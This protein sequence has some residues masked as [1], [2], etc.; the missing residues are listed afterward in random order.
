[1]QFLP[2]GPDIPES[3]Y[4]AHQD[5]KVVFFCGAGISYPAGL[6]GFKGLV[7]QLYEKLGETKNPPEMVA[8]NDTRYDLVID[9]LERRLENRDLVRKKISEILT[10]NNTKPKQY[11]T[12]NALLIL[13]SKSVTTKNSARRLVTTNFDRLFFSADPNHKHFGAPLLPIPKK[14]RWDGVV[15]LHGLLPESPD[16][17]LLSNLVVSSGDFGLAY[18]TERW[19]SRFVTD[20]FRE[21]TVCFVG[22][23]LGDPVLRY[24]VDA[25][26]ADHLRGEEPKEV[27]AFAS[28]PSG[29]G[30]D[31]RDEWEAKGITPILYEEANDHFYLHKSLETWA[32]DYR[33]GVTGKQM[34]VTEHSNSTPDRFQEGG[35]LD[36]MVWALSDPSGHP[37]KLFAEMDPIPPIDWLNVLDEKGL[38]EKDDPEGHI[39]R[40][41][42]VAQG[43]FVPNQFLD[44]VTLQLGRWLVKYLEKTEVMEW[45]VHKRGPLHADFKRL[46]L[47]RLSKNDLPQPVATIWQ[48][49]CA[50]R[51][52]IQARTWGDFGQV[53]KSTGWNSTQRKELLRSLEPIV[54]FE[55]SHSNPF[56][57]D[58]QE[59]SRK[60]ERVHDYLGWDIGLKASDDLRYYVVDDLKKRNDWGSI[61][62]DLLPGLTERLKDA[63][64][65][66]AEL[67]GADKYNDL[68]YYR[69]PSISNH[70]QNKDYYHWTLLIELCRDGWLAAKSQDPGLAR[71]E[72]ERWKLISY[73][74]FRRLVFFAATQSPIVTPE[75]ALELLLAEEARWL[76]STNTQREAFQL[77]RFLAPKLAVHPLERLCSAILAGP[78]PG[79]HKVDSDENEILWMTK[80][81]WLRLK[82]CQ[83]QDGN[84]LPHAAAQ[85][86]KETQDQHPEWK[87]QPEERDD[88]PSWMGEVGVFKDTPPWITRGSVP[89]ALEELVS[90]LAERKESTWEEDDWK[91]L[92]EKEPELAYNALKALADEKKWPIGVWKSALHGFSSDINKQESHCSRWLGSL[93]AQAPEEFNR[94]S[95]HA[96][97]WWIAYQPTVIIQE[98]EPIWFGLIDH[99]LG[100]LR[101][102]EYEGG[103]D[104]NTAAINHPVG[105]V[106]EAMIKYWYLSEPKGGDGLKDPFLSRFTR[107]V[108]DSAQIYLHGRVI[109]AHHLYSLFSVDEE[110]SK[111]YLLPK[112]NW[113]DKNP[114][115]LP[116]W[117]GYLS[118]AKISYPLLDAM[119]SSF[120]Q[121]ASHT[122]ELALSGDNYAALLII[123]ALDKTHPLSKVEIQNALNSLSLEGLAKAS[124][125]LHQML[126]GAG[127]K[128]SEYW[129][130][131]I[132]PLLEGAWPKSANMRSPEESE[133]MVWVCTLAGDSFPDAVETM[134]NLGFIKQPSKHITFLFNLLEKAELASQFPRDTIKLL[135]VMIPEKEISRYQLSEIRKFLNQMVEKDASLRDDQIYITIDLRL[136]KNRL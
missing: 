41:A 89:R 2:K 116:L 40:I 66:M 125:R 51:H 69:R 7:D 134:I 127:D 30:K 60:K 28:H 121:T 49:M 59:G 112:F 115:T 70:S 128:A 1:M 119:K 82:M 78:P 57:P 126:E 93:L 90:Y 21:Y 83:M 52:L 3:L 104:P 39:Q 133:Q 16:S 97:G 79:K 71:V 32:N 98:N 81:K 13:S 35:V 14:S 114:E 75:E 77:L 108:E 92:C 6:P 91:E 106:T 117:E 38:M 109:L 11:S 61:L 24:M 53:I 15:Y 76:W 56:S 67:G 111:K 62:L 36:R 122:N 50:D 23:S 87:L 9:L 95:S 85:W 45:V 19:A 113:A 27:F 12:H 101:E 131:R 68:L 43:N 29:K 88:F 74:I 124:G 8:F 86:L 37:A 123:L 26:S 34:I 47:E 48:I 96:L 72:L 65:L 42:L 84:E 44:E 136:K 25:L 58:F 31:V 46:I 94:K 64:D 63:Y 130:N 132:K 4:Q 73:P 10:P 55:T 105:R 17:V 129:I 103:N 102:E 22:Y 110:W 5:G 80:T 120:L 54:L 33:D 107:L 100:A 18:L 20:L 118:S 99:L 135:E